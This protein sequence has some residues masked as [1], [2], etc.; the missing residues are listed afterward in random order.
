MLKRLFAAKGAPPD[1]D[2]EDAEDD[3]RADEDEDQEDG[4]V[5]SS[6]A[7]IKVKVRW[8]AADQNPFGVRVVDLA[9]FALEMRS[10]S[11]DPQMATNAMSFAGDDGAEFAT[12]TPPSARTAAC[13]LRFRISGPLL[14]GALFLPSAME[15]KWALYLR[16]GRIACV[17]S[18]TR[19]VL[20]SARV[21]VDGDVAIIGPITGTFVD[22]EPAEMTV[23]QLEFLLRTHALREMRPAP[24]PDGLDDLQ[25][26]T[27]AMFSL[28]GRR[29]LFATRETPAPS[30]PLHPLRTDSLLHIAVAR[31]D[32]AAVEAAIANGIPKDVL[33]RDGQTLVHWALASVDP[34]MVAWLLDHGYAV[35]ARSVELATPLMNAV[36]DGQLD[37]VRLLLGRGADVDARDARGFTAL[38][39]AAETG[40]VEVA[41]LLLEHGA[42]ADIVALGE[43]ARS[44]AKQRG[45]RPMI[46]LLSSVARPRR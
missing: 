31:G 23:R 40:S 33:A 45:E 20:V 38:H 46:E 4:D 17:R 16:D 15:D 37:F 3:D 28:W 2:D 36:Q 26:I 18:W 5:A 11:K 1:D 25:P 39:R 10:T 9:P 14:D 7:P 29:A 44:L 22:G 19:R 43:T 21:R 30:S 42:R 13:E 12:Q 6:R 34:D 32:R 41:R 35:D 24:L 8:V 27:A